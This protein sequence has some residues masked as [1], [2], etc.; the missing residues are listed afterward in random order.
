[1]PH[2]LPQ[3]GEW[4]LAEKICLPHSTQGPRASFSL[5]CSSMNG[6]VRPTLVKIKARAYISSSPLPRQGEIDL[7]FRRNSFGRAETLT[8]PNLEI[9]RM[10]FYGSGDPWF[11][12]RRKS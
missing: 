9:W 2:A 8:T 1:M 12:E 3:V 6:N 5:P 4:G 7:E 10:G 11:P